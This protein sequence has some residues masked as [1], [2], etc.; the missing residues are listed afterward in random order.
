MF[1]RQAGFS[2]HS[3]LQFIFDGKRNLSK[4]SVLKFVQGMKMG[5]K[6]A[7]FFAEKYL[8]KKVVT[9][10]KSLVSN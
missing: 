4:K 1:A 2:S 6:K 5:K 8:P 7:E 3:I 9:A 10:L